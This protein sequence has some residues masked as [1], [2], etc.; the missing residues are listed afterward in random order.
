[1]HDSVQG[2]VE[3]TA[4]RLVGSERL[5]LRLPPRVGKSHLARS[6]VSALG[7]S[8]VL[9]SGASFTEPNQASIREEIEA[10]L[11]SAIETH[12]SAQLIFDSYDQAL[13]RSQGPRLQSWLTGRLID[14]P[15]AQDIGAL[16]TARCGTQI[17]RPGAGS[18]IMSRVTPI[19][20]PLIA[21]IPDGDDE[22]RAHEWFGGS[23]LLLAQA[24]ADGHFDPTLVADRLEQDTSYLGDVKKAGAAAIARGCL[25]F[26]RDSFATRSAAHG[27]VTETGTTTL[28]GRLREVLLAEAP[29]DPGWPDS[30]DA[31]IAKFCRLAAGATELIWSDRYMYRDVEPLRAFL[32]AVALTTR[33]TIRL[34][35][36][37][38]VGERHISRAEMA[39]INSV[40]GVEA[41]WMTIPDFRD[42]HDR[43]LHTGTG[44]WVVP[45]VH[46]VIGRQAPG[47]AIA[48]PTNSFGVDYISIFNRSTIP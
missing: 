9:V 28:F 19:D 14:S 36:G 10:R 37:E 3:K 13:A 42:L 38:T 2:W 25:D 32:Q 6:I 15:Y 23:A 44:G 21:A 46:V 18:P 31:S 43:H 8:A 47:N 35:G 29:D 33:C 39:R 16:F 7:E 27:L 20:P 4:Y 30:W 5:L 45:Q 40:P 26:E 22:T 24:Y 17:Q 48:S 12:G 1:M 41:R 11:L 34:L